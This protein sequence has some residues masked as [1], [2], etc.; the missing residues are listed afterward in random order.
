MAAFILNSPFQALCAIEAIK[1]YEV[2]ES[3]FYILNDSNSREK[4][5]KILDGRG[6]IQ[7]VDHANSGTADLV[8]NLSGFK[9]RFK[10]VF[11]GDYFSYVQYILTVHLAYSGASVIYLDDGSSTIDIIPPISRHRYDTSNEKI[12]FYLFGFA[13]FV[14]RLKYEFF[15]MFDIATG[16]K[17]PCVA[18]TFSSLSSRECQQLAGVFIIGTNSSQVPFKEKT[19][20]QYL[21]DITSFVRNN[22]PLQF[23]YYCPHRRDK[24]DHRDKLNQSGILFFDTEISVEVDFSLNGIYPAVV[25]GFCSTALI[26]LRRMFPLSK[27]YSVYFETEKEEYDLSYRNLEE[28]YRANNIIILK[29]LN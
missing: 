12:G 1:V 25:I 28:Y 19:Y 5:I 26:T 15:S 9:E 23:I 24:N 7:L 8:K 18:N 20:E 2:E 6:K 29:D 17:Y 10:R 3:V 21:D 4:A 22:Y 27:I 14:K 11:V 16:I 13:A